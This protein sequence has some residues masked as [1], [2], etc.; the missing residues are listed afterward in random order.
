MV[1][2]D[3]FSSELVL[4]RGHANFLGVYGFFSSKRL[5]NSKFRN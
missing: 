3:V 4:F 1:G 2:S 5:N